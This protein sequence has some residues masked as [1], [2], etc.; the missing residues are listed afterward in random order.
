MAWFHEIPIDAFMVREVHSLNEKERMGDA[1]AKMKFYNIRHLPIVNDNNEV[2]GVFSFTDLQRA[3][4]PRETQSGWY[5]SKE[6]LNCL[7]LKHYASNNPTLLT[8]YDTLRD[9]ASIIVRHKIGCI[10]IVHPGGRTLAGIITY[11]DILK[12]IAFQL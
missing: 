7:N 1:Y 12:C 6:E 2:V 8:P 9:A 3:Y 10:P 5:Y 4:P 11:I